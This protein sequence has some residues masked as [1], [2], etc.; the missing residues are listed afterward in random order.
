MRL[1]RVPAVTAEA[2][3]L[4]TFDLDAGRYPKATGLGV[5]VDGVQIGTVFD[6][7]RV[8][9]GE[10]GVHAAGRVLWHAV[11]SRDDLAIR[12]CQHLPPIS[13]VVRIV[14]AVLPQRF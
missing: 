10:V 4:T 9:W 13:V 5:S 12:D 7:H 11:D 14:L 8:P 3:H 2:E 1:A 6:E